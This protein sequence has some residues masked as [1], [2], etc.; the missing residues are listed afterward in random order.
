MLRRRDIDRLLLTMLRSQKGVSELFSTVERPLPV[1]SSGKLVDV[2]TDPPIHRLSPY[3]AEMLAF[4]LLNGDKRN[5]ETL[6]KTG[7]CACAYELPG[8]CRFRVNVFQQRKQ[9]SIVMRKLESHIMSIDELGLPEI[10][11]DMAKEKNG[12]ILVTGSTGSGK[13]TTL[14]ALL[15]EMNETRPI[16]ILTLEDPIEF[17]HPIKTAPFNQREKGTDF[18]SFANGLKAAL[19]QA[20]KVIL[21]GE[22]RDRETVDIGLAAAATGHLVVSTLHSIDCG[23]TINRIVGMFDKDEELQIRARLAETVRYVVNQRLLV[24]EGG[25][26]VAAQEIM[27]MN[28][29]IKELVLKGEQKDKSFYDVIGLNT[30]LG[31]Q[32]YDQCMVEH[33]RAGKISEETALASASRRSVLARAIAS[34]KR[35]APRSPAPS[36]SRSIPRATRPRRCSRSTGLAPRPCSPSRSSSRTRAT[37]ASTPSRAA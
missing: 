28:L 33:Y 11:K 16:H 19:R 3:Q 29:R 31:W 26:R 22:M 14:A 18:D 20:P 17:V 13:S 2:K 10:F 15:N 25:G 4:G 9:Y 27:G 34:N 6:A 12:L 35:R 24:K 30:N 7:S 1:E 36:A 37:F 23:Q 8:H 21:V 5:M 32:N